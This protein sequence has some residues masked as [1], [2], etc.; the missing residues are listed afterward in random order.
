MNK[1]LRPYTYLLSVHVAALL[2]LSVIRLFFYIAVKEQIT[3]DAAGN[4]SWICAAFLR[5]L[6]FDNVIACYITALPLLAT[7]V[8]AALN[9]WKNRFIRTINIWYA[10]FYTLVFMAA[11]SNIPYFVYF[12]KPLNA[13]IWNWAEYGTTTMGMIFG[14][15]AYYPYI[16]LFVASTVLFI[17]FLRRLRK[18]FAK[19]PQDITT[20]SMQPSVCK[21][22]TAIGLQAHYRHRPS[23]P[24]SRL[25][26]FH[27]HQ[28]SPGLQPHQSQ[29]RLFLHEPR[30]EQPGSQCNLCIAQQH[31][32]RSPS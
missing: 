20:G 27:R 11:A 32:R 13:S 28:R 31:I 25:A 12:S 30:I 16:L 23:D 15:S 1:I 4:A 3:G 5:G 17:W 10:A 2:L 24:V 7:S 9:L 22:I 19:T 8:A 26:L 6:W 14:E 29:C 18:R 21:H